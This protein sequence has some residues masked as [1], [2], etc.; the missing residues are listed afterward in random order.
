MSGFLLRVHKQK[1][2]S[3]EK[4]EQLLGDSIQTV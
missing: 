3:A 2:L 4:D 1:E